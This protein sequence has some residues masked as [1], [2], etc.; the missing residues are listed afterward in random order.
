MPTLATM[1]RA[2][3]VKTAYRISNWRAGVRSA[4]A[5][6]MPTLVRA[7]RIPAALITSKLEA[8]IIRADGTVIDL[9]VISRR[10][11]TTAG[12]NY[13]ASSFLNTTEPENFNFH[14][15]G[16]GVGAEAVGDTALGT[17]VETRATGTQSNP[18]ANLYRTVGTITA[19]AARSVTEHGI[20]S[21]SSA[22]T[23]LDRSVFTAIALA[24]S[25]SIQFTYTLTLTAGG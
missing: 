17:E 23:L 7:L 4:P 19:T 9:G 1:R 16:T 10:V 24:I 22:G 8:K 3:D 14:G 2:H 13:L 18:S 15:M 11:V 20:F 6:V 25:D 12:V 5:I 21:A